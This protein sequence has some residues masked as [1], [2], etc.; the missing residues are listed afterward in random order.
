MDIEQ[1]QHLVKM[2][3]PFAVGLGSMLDNTGVPIFFVVG[4]GMTH[5]LG[6]SS[7]LLLM[8]A[9]LGSVVGD[10][11]TYAIGRYF[12]TRDRILLSSIGNNIKPLLEIGDKAM[13]QWGGVCTLIF[14]R[15]IPYVGKVTP[16][17]AGSYQMNWLRAV[18]SVCIGSV[19]LMGLFHVYADNVF[20]VV[21]GNI[22]LVRVLSISIGTAAL[23][24]LYCVNRALKKSANFNS[25]LKYL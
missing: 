22:T 3:G 2:Y 15:F 18:L 12:L 9:V 20:E 8:T 11:G 14:G 24:T 25:D 19:L 21:S 17:L 4:M 16:L 13:R 10:L 6:I 1:V 23:L 7:K 5:S